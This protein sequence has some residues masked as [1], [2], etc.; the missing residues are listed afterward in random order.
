M[1]LHAN[2]QYVRRVKSA[3][4]LLLRS[5]CRP[6]QAMRSPQVESFLTENRGW[7]VR[8][9]QPIQKGTFIVEYAGTPVG[10]DAFCA[11]AV[12]CEAAAAGTFMLLAGMNQ[13]G[14]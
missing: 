8:A 5:M 10:A 4:F 13:V 2:W 12:L 3:A 7:G 9:S 1:V 14:P 11:A 6:F